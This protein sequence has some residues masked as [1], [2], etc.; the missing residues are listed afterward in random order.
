LSVEAVHE[1]LSELCV[2]LETLRFVGVLGGDVSAGQLLVVPE[3]DA[4]AD[5]LPVASAASTASV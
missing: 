4:F 5:R 2:W 1:S 3:I